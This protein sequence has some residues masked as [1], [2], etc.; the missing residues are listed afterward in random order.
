MFLVLIDVTNSDQLGAAV[1]QLAEGCAVMDAAHRRVG[2]PAWRTQ[3]GGFAGLAR[4]IVYQQ[5]STKA[6]ATVWA[7]LEERFGKVTPEIMLAVDGAA[8]RS[9]G[10][11]KPKVRHMQSVAAAVDDGSLDFARLAAASDDEAR[12]ELV[13]VSGIGPWTADVYLMCCLG[14]TDVF[15]HADIGLSEAWRMIKGEAERPT[16]EAFLEIG[17]AWRPHRG[18]AAHLL[19][20]YINAVRE[21]D[22]GS[23]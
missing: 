19:W 5:V 20:A 7:R 11:S 4:I 17:E 23:A 18:V 14:R 22:A 10:L 3:P 8:L 9:C 15:P 16:P 13:A 6:A 2:V 21:P 12:A 1:K